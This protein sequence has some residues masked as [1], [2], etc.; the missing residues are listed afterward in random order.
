MVVASVVGPSVVVV[1]VIVV[2]VVVVVVAVSVV[3]VA[4]PLLHPTTN[5][6]EKRV[7]P[8]IQFLCTIFYLATILLAL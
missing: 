1:I 6:K 7:H 5:I 3:V 8:R 4:S 2:V